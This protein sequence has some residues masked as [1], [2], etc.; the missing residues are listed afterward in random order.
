M[1]DKR[2]LPIIE[3]SNTRPLANDVPLNILHLNS[4]RWDE[5]LLKRKNG[6]GL[7]NRSGD[8]VESRLSRRYPGVGSSG[9]SGRQCRSDILIS[10]DEL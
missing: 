1:K 6:D 5:I 4:H 8:V 7:L 9:G 3:N 2:D 10:T